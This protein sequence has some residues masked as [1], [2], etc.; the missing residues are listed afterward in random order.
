MRHPLTIGCQSCQATRY[1]LLSLGGSHTY[2]IISS[3]SQSGSQSQCCRT[4][5]ELKLKLAMD[6]N[7]STTINSVD[8][9]T[10]PIYLK[11]ELMYH[12]V[13]FEIVT[14]YMIH[15]WNP[16]VF[17]EPNALIRVIGAKGP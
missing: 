13:S 10:I 9:Q 1:N 8:N 5:S 3:L 4:L 17:L 16:W 14:T 15:F 2:I 6:R 11:I 12:D 7:D